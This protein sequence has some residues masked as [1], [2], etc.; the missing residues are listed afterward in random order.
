VGQ[1][2][3]G[4]RRRAHVWPE[5]LLCSGQADVGRLPEAFHSALGGHL[6]HLRGVD[7]GQPPT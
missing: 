5:F 3:E 2:K 1:G 7:K 6:S 4:K